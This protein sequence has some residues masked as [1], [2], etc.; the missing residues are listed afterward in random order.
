MDF[1]PSHVSIA[2]PIPAYAA[3]DPE[4]W[5]AR[6]QLFFRHRRI[7]DEATML[8]LALSAMP[9]EFLSQLRDFILI[10]DPEMSPFTAFK[11]LCLE[12]LAE[13]DEQRIRQALLCEDLAGRTPSA[14]LRRLQQIWPASAALQESSVLRQLF[15]R[16]PP[17]QLQAALLPFTEKP[18]QELAVLADRLSALQTPPPSVSVS[19]VHSVAERLDR[20]EQIVRQLTSFPT[21]ADPPRQQAD[22]SRHD[23]FL[24]HRPRLA[25]HASRVLITAVSDSERINARRHARGGNDR[26]AR[27]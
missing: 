22:D 4:L 3:S 5:F 25:R 12:R 9:D 11:R 1:A 27:R 13:N 14:L 7:Q 21:L 18:L 17:H 26:G 24:P 20:L 6:L 23:V 16:R 8:E 10:A 2:L 19:A 15:L